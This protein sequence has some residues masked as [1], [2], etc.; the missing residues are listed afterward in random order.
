MDALYISSRLY[1]NDSAIKEKEFISNC[2]D[3][4]IHELQ[5]DIFAHRIINKLK[6]VDN[7]SE[8]RCL[9]EA[10]SLSTYPVIHGKS[11]SG[12]SKYFTN[13]LI[14]NGQYF[15][16]WPDDGSIGEENYRTAANF[17]WW[18]YLHGNGDQIISDIINL[19]YH[20]VT[21]I[22]SIGK[23]VRNNISALKNADNATIIK[24]WYKANFL[25]E[26]NSIYGYKG[27]KIYVY[28]ANNPSG[29]VSLSKYCAVYTTPNMYSANFSLL[30]KGIQME[31]LKNSRG[32]E[33]LLIFNGS[34]NTIEVKINPNIIR[35]RSMSA[36][37][38]EENEWFD[39]VYMIDE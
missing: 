30:G 1:M 37:I 14:R 2:I 11:S 12:R 35:V 32:E 36:E 31:R 34:Q 28:Q 4:I 16:N 13:D 15:F 38:E 39:Y 25:N 5:H 26:A 23:A 27:N 29:K 19:D 8:K 20:K 3:T 22:D 7:Y 10:L 21:D 17:M 18:L 9:T 33:W 6:F 24:T